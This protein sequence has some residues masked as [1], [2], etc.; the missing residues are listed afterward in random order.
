MFTNDSVRFFFGANTPR[1]FY[2]F[3]QTDLYDP[4]DGWIAF[5]I[6]SGAGTGKATFMRAAADALSQRGH[7]NETVLC[8]SDPSSVDA[9]IVPSLKLCVVDATAP[10]VIEPTAYGE[11]EQLVP[12]GCCLRPEIAM[13]QTG[14]W[15]AAADA[16]A[17]AHARC[18][19]FLHAANSLL[20]TSRRLITPSV[21]TEKLVASAKRLARRE[22]GVPNTTPGR[23]IRRFLSAV[24]PE[25]HR[26]LSD[27]ATTLCPR[28]YVLED[29]YKA[30]APTYMALLADE[31][32]A[33]GHEAM[34]CPCPLSPTDIE[35]VLIPSLGVG[36]LTSNRFHKV[37]F[38][39]Y[40]RIHAVRFIDADAIAAHKQQLRFNRRAAISLLTEAVDASVCAKEHHD[41]ME[42]LHQ[43]AMD[44]EAYSRLTDDAMRTLLRIADER[45]RVD[46]P[47]LV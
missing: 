22:F 1:G 17:A 42:A 7:A 10:H 26:F 20:D 44:W 36:F 4:R 46:E 39:V 35:H 2:G 37:E 16:C 29:D 12:L 9:V 47:T 45:S 15:F 19:R 3:H 38:P 18:C 40:R 5:L 6:K 13:R 43:R 21:H 30:V 8:S 34:V 27:T 24:T 31:A 32:V 25:G 33:A 41:H 14:E 23:R 11:C 28:L